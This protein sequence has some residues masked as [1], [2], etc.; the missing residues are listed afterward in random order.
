MS[1]RFQKMEVHL[2]SSATTKP[3]HAQELTAT[4]VPPGGTP[5][6]RY[7][8][9]VVQGVVN[10]GRRAEVEC[11]CD[12]GTHQTR[13]LD[14]LK[15][16]VKQGQSPACLSCLAKRTAI[17]G[18]K[19]FDP[20]RYIG[21][22]YGRLL[23]VGVDVNL[24]RNNVKSR[25]VC[26]CDC[27]GQAVVVPSDLVKRHTTSCGCFHHE[28]QVQ[29]GKERI[30][31]GHTVFGVLNGHTPL[32]RA[33][34]K[35]RAGVREGWAKGF[36]KV[37]H[38]YDP[39][40]EEYANFLADFGDIRPDQTISRLDNQEPWSKENCFMNIGRRRPKTLAVE[41]G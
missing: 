23:A 25:L 21:K 24:E 17:N 22:R 2:A 10:P 18:V 13:R 4:R 27:G 12:C 39:R 6:A 7:G 37:C 38:E 9:L 20:A 35:I 40:W 31:H 16:T 36:H 29:L 30:E 28:R 33:W 19:R 34:L 15:R 8:S 11:R 32:Y 3:S 5:G 1:E 41:E 14:Q 26:R